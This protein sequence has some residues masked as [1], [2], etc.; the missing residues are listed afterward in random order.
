[1]GKN[2]PPPT[3]S[4]WAARKGNSSSSSGRPMKRQLLPRI[5]QILLAT[6]IKHLLRH[7]LG[8]GRS[9]RSR[10]RAPQEEN[11]HH[12][13]EAVAAPSTQTRETCSNASAWDAAL[14]RS[15]PNM[16]TVVGWEATVTF[17]LA[18][19]VA[20]SGRFAKN[21]SS[22]PFA[23][24]PPYLS[25]FPSPKLPGPFNP[26]PTSLSLAERLTFELQD[27]G[28]TVPESQDGKA[29]SHR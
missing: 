15:P 14:A 3:G 23:S 13:Q 11:C 19:F 26:L 4:G 28:W 7:L 9:L 5:A 17:W 25:F 22:L 6:H 24:L 1:M 16:A 18:T 21:S 8:S 29:S 12:H 20:C 2:P 27:R 10:P